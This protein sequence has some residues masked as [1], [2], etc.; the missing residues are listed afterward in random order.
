MDGRDPFGNGGYS[1]IRQ[2][3]RTVVPGS[4]SR[5]RHPL[6]PAQPRDHRQ[7]LLK[8][9]ERRTGR[10]VPVGGVGVGQR[11]RSRGGT[12]SR[13]KSRFKIA[14]NRWFE[15]RSP[16]RAAVTSAVGALLRSRLACA[17]RARRRVGHTVV[18]E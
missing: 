10:H 3:S 13:C 6:A 2:S 4:P 16:H 14:R 17:I 15:I 12:A 11:N 18:S 8:R 7:D 5:S 9:P 1:W